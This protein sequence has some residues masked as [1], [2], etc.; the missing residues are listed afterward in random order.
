MNKNGK[1]INNDFYKIFYLF[2]SFFKHKASSNTFHD[3]HDLVIRFPKTQH[4]RCLGNKVW[5]VWF[6]KLQYL[7]GLL[8]ICSGVS[9]QPVIQQIQKIFDREKEYIY[10][11]KDQSTYNF[12]PI[13]VQVFKLSKTL[14]KALIFFTEQN[15]I[16]NVFLVC[17]NYNRLS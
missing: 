4:D 9:N 10:W 3:S 11:G 12:I 6:Y 13:H 17:I 5:G 15:F 1:N 16:H 7:K 2:V 14:R 8:V